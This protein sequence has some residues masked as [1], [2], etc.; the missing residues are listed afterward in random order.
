MAT[1]DLSSHFALLGKLIAE[2]FDKLPFKLPSGIEVD[3]KCFSEM[4]AGEPQRS[5]FLITKTEATFEL[6]CARLRQPAKH[7]SLLIKKEVIPVLVG[8]VRD[9]PSRQH[10]NI[11]FENPVLQMWRPKLQGLAFECLELTVQLSAKS[12]MRC[13]QDLIAAGVRILQS[14]NERKFDPAVKEAYCVLSGKIY[15]FLSAALGSSL[16][17]DLLPTTTVRDLA[18][19]L[20]NDLRNASSPSLSHQSTTC[21]LLLIQTRSV[22]L[23]ADVKDRIFSGLVT[24][25]RGIIRI[26]QDRQL[27]ALE[28]RALNRIFE[29]VNCFV[30]STAVHIGVLNVCCAIFREGLG[31][32][33]TDVHITCRM[34][35]QVVS[36]VL[37][38][39]VPLDVLDN[40][41]KLTE[42]ASGRLQA[43][44]NGESS[45]RPGMSDRQ[46]GD[47]FFVPS[48][49]K[50][51]FPVVEE[52]VRRPED[53]SIVRAPEDVSLAKASE[54]VSM[55]RAPEDVSMMR[56]PEDVSMMRAPED[57]VSMVR[58]P[59]DV[60]MVRAPEDVSMVRAPEVAYPFS[61]PSGVTNS[62][63][64]DTGTS[65]E[66]EPSVKRQKIVPEAGVLTS[67][68]TEMS[69]ETIDLIASFR[70][71][72]TEEADLEA[73]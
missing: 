54:D 19:C 22:D 57:N 36:G 18:D 11:S 37:R 17:S 8:I 10:G 12:L 6:I 21:L 50:A 2:V 60:S 35:L 65:S 38:P 71:I 5:E 39:R 34:G 40:A 15:S 67:N 42:P 26:R 44:T 66:V 53:V 63:A 20:L 1:V 56:A 14:R 52:G 73:D 70:D 61:T 32:G 72:S 24:S 46:N 43:S 28:A 48:Q 4:P 64:V 51:T 16:I 59:E 7:T 68:D 41:L 3:L 47:G 30:L 62:T 23:K 13:S 27:T 25:A 55:M 49:S 58:A 9:S 31:V 33:D 69:T 45:K 29:A